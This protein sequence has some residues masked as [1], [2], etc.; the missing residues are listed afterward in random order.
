MKKQALFVLMLSSLI[1]TACNNPTSSSESSRSEI[2]SETTSSQTSE[3]SAQST[4]SSQS[5]Q[6]TQS[7]QSSQTSGN[8]EVEDLGEKDTHT[9][10]MSRYLADPD[11]TSIKTYVP[12][13][14]AEDSSY[15]NDQSQPNPIALTFN[16]VTSAS[17]YYVQIAKNKEFTNAKLVESTTK[18]YNFYNSELGQEYYYR[19]AT[20][21]NALSAAKVY[22]FKVK[23]AAPRYIHAEGVI[24][25]R[26]SG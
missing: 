2:S 26:D 7:T 3:S 15:H 14:N 1:L 23:D 25:F 17:K 22:K 8:G 6:S 21:E 10:L 16:E 18:S 20:S 5:T 12:K 11:W 19:A 4:E 24:N 13:V 9:D